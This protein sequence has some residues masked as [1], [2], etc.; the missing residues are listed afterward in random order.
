[1]I[2]GIE[3]LDLDSTAQPTRDEMELAVGRAHAITVEVREQRD[4]ARMRAQATDKENLKLRAMLD[5][6]RRARLAA[7]GK[8]LA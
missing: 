4:K 8:G 7:E 2:F 1:M 3:R 5:D 6:E